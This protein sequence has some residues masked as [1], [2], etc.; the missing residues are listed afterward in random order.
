MKQLYRYFSDDYGTQLVRDGKIR[1]GTFAKYQKMEL[2]EADTTRGDRDDGCKFI[3]INK[4]TGDGQVASPIVQ[5]LT[6]TTNP[7]GI[8]IEN[9][10]VSFHSENLLVMCM[11]Q[12]LSVAIAQDF[13]NATECVQINDPDWFFAAITKALRRTRGRN[14]DFL[15][16]FPCSYVPS[17]R[18]KHTDDTAHIQDQYLLKHESYRRQEEVRALWRYN[19]G[20]LQDD[21]IDLVCP[22]IGRYCSLVDFRVHAGC[23]YSYKIFLG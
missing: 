12:V 21:H 20:K 8:T 7:R 4:Y 22:N 19:C 23:G 3:E 2:E 17:R 10:L 18:V 9:C 1:L 16:W 15:G 14:F 11:S 13:D 6:G 5:M